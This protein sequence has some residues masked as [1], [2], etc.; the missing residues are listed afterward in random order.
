MVFLN[1]CLRWT[2]DIRTD[3]RIAV[4][5]EFTD[6]TFFIVVIGNIYSIFILNSIAVFKEI[7]S[8]IVVFVQCDFQFFLVT[9]FF[10]K[11]HGKCNLSIL[12]WGGGVTVLV[13]PRFFEGEVGIWCVCTVRT[14][15][16]GPSKHV[17]AEQDQQRHAEHKEK[18]PA[19]C[20]YLSLFLHFHK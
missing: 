12:R 9:S 18:N 2:G 14:I 19:V 7:V 6:A 11:R 16:T 4:N 20:E 15:T 17:A 1:N 13:Q 3:V 8:P 10:F 5:L